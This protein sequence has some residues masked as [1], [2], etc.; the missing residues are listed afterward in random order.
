MQC[1]LA[2]AGLGLVVDVVVHESGGVN[3]LGG[4]REIHDLGL[5]LAA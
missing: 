4:E 3:D 5:V 2:A 1:R